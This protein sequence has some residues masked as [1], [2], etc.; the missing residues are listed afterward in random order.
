MQEVLSI[1][2]DVAAELA[3]VGDP[4]LGALRER[5]DCTIRLRGNQLTLEGD[6]TRVAEFA[7]D[8]WYR[9][10]PERAAQAPFPSLEELP[11]YVYAD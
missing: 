4:V 10:T 9:L 3:G 5:L 8:L 6:E 2:N 1:S 11:S 7:G